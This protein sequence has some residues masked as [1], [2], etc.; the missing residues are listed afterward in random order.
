M[1]KSNTKGLKVSIGGRMFPIRVSP[2]DV[3][4]VKGIVEEINEKVAT[5]QNTYERKDKQDCLSMALLTYAVDYHKLVQ[6]MDRE[7][8][9]EQLDKLSLLL[10]NAV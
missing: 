6:E 3:E 7:N 2:E 4:T 5:Y 10:D 8:I 1:D 9:S